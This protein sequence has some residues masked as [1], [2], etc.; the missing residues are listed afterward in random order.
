M[1]M[2]TKYIFLINLTISQRVKKFC[3]SMRNKMFNFFLVFFPV[4][5]LPSTYSLFYAQQN[6]LEKLTSDQVI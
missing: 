2:K 1:G 6:N 4:A 3:L 5:F